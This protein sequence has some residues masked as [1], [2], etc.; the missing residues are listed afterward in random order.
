MA[1]EYVELAN[2]YH[3]DGADGGTTG[4]LIAQN[5]ATAELPDR[6]R[7]GKLIRELA[8]PTFFSALW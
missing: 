3:P 2:N 5:D 6:P 8:A 1:S 7:L 4:V